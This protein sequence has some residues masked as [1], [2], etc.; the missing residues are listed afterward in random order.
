MT[1]AA[2]RRLANHLHESMLRERHAARPGATAS[3]V[4]R[5]IDA[6][7]ARLYGAVLDP[8]RIGEVGHAAAEVYVLL[9]A[10]AE[11]RLFD[12]EAAAEALVSERR[13]ARMRAVARGGRSSLGAGGGG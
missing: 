2:P 12:L 7:H 9:V 1:V 10:L 3:T 8:G 6:A 11:T 4:M 5:E 13:S